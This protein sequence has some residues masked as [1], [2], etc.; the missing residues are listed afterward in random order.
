MTFISKSKDMLR[1]FFRRRTDEQTEKRDVNIDVHIYYPPNITLFS[2]KSQE[3]FGK[4]N[5]TILH[6]KDLEKLGSLDV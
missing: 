5:D 6:K 2:P 3:T 1:N 4:Q